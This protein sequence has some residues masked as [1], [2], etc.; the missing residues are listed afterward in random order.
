L[1]AWLLALTP[2][3]CNPISARPA[4]LRTAIDDHWERF[5]VTHHLSRATGMV[6]MRHK[7]TE[8]AANDPAGTARILEG[9]LAAKAEPDGALALA[10]LSYQAG[11]TRA[12]TA[13]RE[14][15]GWYRDA[16]ALGW[17][18]L[19]DPAGT[20]SDLAVAI[21]NGAVARLVR[22]SQAVARRENRNWRQVLEEAG[23]TVA[24]GAPYLEPARI[25]DLRVAADLRVKGMNHIYRSNGL[26]VPLVAH[27]V[28]LRNAPAPGV[29]DEFLPRDLRTGATAV[30]APGGGL[31]GGD[32]RRS[33]PALVLLDPFGPAEETIGGKPVAL[34]GD[35]T[36]PLAAL[37]GG[38][39]AAVL[40]WTGLF[41]SG[42][43]QLGVKSGLYMIRPYEPGKIPVVFVHGLFSSPR[44]WVQTINELR[45]SPALAERYQFW[46]FLYP[47]GLPIPA[48]AAR[49]RESLV[50]ARETLDPGHGDG[51][52]DRMVVIGH[53]MGGVLS[54][55]MA[56]GTGNTL[57]DA[58]IT[59]PRERFRAPPEIQ[60]SLDGL[61]VFEP[62]PFVRRVVFVATPHRGSPI[63]NGPVGWT[64]SR[65]VR[66]PAAG[67]D[68]L[69]IIEALN[70]PNVVSP[71]LRGAALNAI[72]NLRTDSPILAA[73]DRIPIEPTVPYHSI[74]PLIG[75]VTDTDGVVEYRSSR[76]PG[77]VSEL[78][79]AGTHFSQQAPEVTRELRR[80]L[81]DHVAE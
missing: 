73:L 27:R 48:S 26:G 9:R 35:R 25:A 29:Q 14:A 80:I 41:D 58:A 8:M 5:E 66:G 55:M 18:A 7:L 59:V 40:E 74:I 79:V 57:W 64:V 31:L 16:A 22:A 34:A 15:L 1:V 23:T 56:Q 51:A 6:L 28:V 72:G 39:L 46:V 67:A 36:A 12:G 19:A 63:A 69:A 45:N 43:K 62:L 49:L 65:L 47:T 3:G 70:G 21:H 24:A 13:P 32:W 42:F 77:A 81:L 75:A 2:A 20:R 30:L 38:R 76:V 4:L 10:E 53:S 71:E 44:A 11:L 50:R 68:R 54:K 60:Q 78:I 37:V 61:L 33:P 17:L 52:L